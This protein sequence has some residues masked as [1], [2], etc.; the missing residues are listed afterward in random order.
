VKSAAKVGDD[1][2]RVNAI[3]S[4]VRLNRYDIDS[5][6]YCLVSIELRFN[7]FILYLIKAYLLSRNQRD[8]IFNS[9]TIIYK[10]FDF[11]RLFDELL[12]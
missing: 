12:N 3:V 1:N 2:A 9:L 8:I 7:N 5:I 4:G 11:K 10:Q 6:Y